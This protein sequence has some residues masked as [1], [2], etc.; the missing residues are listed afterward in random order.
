YNPTIAAAAF[1][2]SNAIV[3][4]VHNDQ[5]LFRVTALRQDLVPDAHM[6][7]GWSDVRGLDFPTIWYNRYLDAVPDRIEWLKYGSIF[8]S[9]DSPLLRVLNV[10]YVVVSK[11][12]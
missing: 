1:Y 5:T 4:R 11:T 6:L 10:K 8:S 9:V 2:P 12:N 3:S 7:F